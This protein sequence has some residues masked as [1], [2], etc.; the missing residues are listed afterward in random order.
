MSAADSKPPAPEPEK[1]SRTGKH[2]KYSVS[3]MFFHEYTLED[4]LR[5]AVSAGCDSVEFWLETPVFWVNEM[6]KDYMSNPDTAADR[7]LKELFGRFPQLSPITV[8]TPVLDLNPC[9]VNPD[10]AR[11]STLWARRALITAHNLGAEVLTLHPGRRTAKRQPGVYDYLKLCRFLDS[12]DAARKELKAKAKTSEHS[13]CGVANANAG[14]YAGENADVAVAIENMQP[15][16]NALL[17][18]PGQMKYF[19]DGGVC[20]YYNNYECEEKPDDIAFRYLRMNDMLPVKGGTGNGNNGNNGNGDSR[21]ENEPLCFTF[22]ISH[23]LA[24][25]GEKTTEDAIRYIDMYFDKIVNVH[26]GGTQSNRVHLPVSQSPEA[27]D[28]LKYLADCGYKR[29]ITLEIDDLNLGKTLTL[30]EKKEFIA[31][32][33]GLLRAIFE[34]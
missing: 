6:P 28:V 8:H 30:N 20:G 13:A 14:R 12:I 32:E 5:S 17:T 1:A 16:V 11:V 33:I 2:P 4:I 31:G 27:Q 23:A 21:G 25:A 15:A 22:D 29:H 18:D 34:G 3:T 9:S 10:I 19:L 26:A 24:G 7:Y